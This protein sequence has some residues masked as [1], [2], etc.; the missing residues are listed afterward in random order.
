MVTAGEQC[1]HSPAGLRQS[2]AGTPRLGTS[3][4]KPEKLRVLEL[5]RQAVA[6][7]SL[8]RFQTQMDVILDNLL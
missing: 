3:L 1:S 7:P 2:R 5:C 8:E 6:S 4:F